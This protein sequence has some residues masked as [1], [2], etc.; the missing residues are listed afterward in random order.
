MNCPKHSTRSVNCK[1]QQPGNGNRENNLRTHKFIAKIA[2]KT[3]T[4]VT[5]STVVPVVRTVRTTT[6]L[7]GTTG[8]KY[9]LD[10][11]FSN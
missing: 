6:F 2:N 3:K 5:R 11:C 10:E 9:Y 8:H 7:R 4:N 1:K